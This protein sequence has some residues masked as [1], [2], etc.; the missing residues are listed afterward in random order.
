MKAFYFFFSKSS[1][2][3]NRHII[4]RANRVL[5]LGNVLILSEDSIVCLVRILAYSFSLKLL[6]LAYIIRFCSLK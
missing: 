5:I 6:G 4:V 2:S 3:Q 1:P